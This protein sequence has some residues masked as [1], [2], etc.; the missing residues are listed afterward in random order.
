[1]SACRWEGV[2]VL[3]LVVEAA[4][5]NTGDMALWADARFVSSSQKPYLAVDDL[6]FNLA[7]QVTRSNILEYVSARDADGNDISH[8]ITY[9]TDYAGQSSGTFT[10]TYTVTD[11]AG[12]RHSR[13]ALPR[14]TVSARRRG[15][16]ILY[17][18]KIQINYKRAVFTA[19]LFVTK[20]F[21]PRL[22]KAVN[23]LPLCIFC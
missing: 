11:G 5:A 14:R 16:N 3:Q 13:G 6:E 15:R 4:G 23:E 8:N 10:V 1:M 19:L 12:G 21:C 22:S 9:T 18:E 2:Q 20:Y 7:S 17:A